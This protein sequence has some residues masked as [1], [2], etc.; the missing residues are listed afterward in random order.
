MNEIITIKRDNLKE[1]LDEFF[2]KQPE[3]VFIMDLVPTGE[4]TLF[5]MYPE[6]EYSVTH[7]FATFLDDIKTQR[8]KDGEQGVTY[9]NAEQM[10][11]FIFKIRNFKTDKNKRLIV[12]CKNG[13]TVSGAVAQWA[14]D[15]LMDG[16]E[17]AFNKLNPDI[18]PNECLQYDLYLHPII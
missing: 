17:A 5:C 18:R 10:Q 1:R 7:T 15:W 9:D 3:H 16:D 4:S 6:T 13:L 12:A 2:D 14:M 8:P 11:N